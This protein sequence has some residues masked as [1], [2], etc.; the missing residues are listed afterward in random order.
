MRVYVNKASIRGK[1]Q[2]A[3]DDTEDALKNKLVEIAVVL[4]TRAPVSTG[5]YAESFSVDTSGGRSIR[6]VSSEGKRWYSA[7]LATAQNA[8]LSNMTNDINAIEVL[9]SNQVQFKNGAPHAAEVEQE[10]QVFGAAK[11]RFR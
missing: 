4:S 9:Q 11:D 1:I 10:H 7:D 5:A 3:M 6:R 8:A 2:D